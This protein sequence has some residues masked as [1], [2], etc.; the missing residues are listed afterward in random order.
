MRI[1]EERA[2]PEVEEIG[3]DLVLVAQIG[4]RD[5]FEQVA[6]DDV[7]LLLSGEMAAWLS[8]HV[9]IP[10]FRYANLNAG[11]F[12]FQQGR[13]KGNRCPWA[14]CLPMRGPA[15]SSARGSPR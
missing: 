9:E 7:D 15:G 5:A 12:Q 4:D 14:A 10:P 6:F 11:F 2:L 13:N 8:G 1:L 3:A